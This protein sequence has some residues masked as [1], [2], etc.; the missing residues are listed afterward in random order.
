M[1]LPYPSPNSRLVV[2]SRLEGGNKTNGGQETGNTER[3]LVGGTSVARGDWAAGRGWWG[4]GAG[5]GVGWLLGV[6]S[7]AGD[8]GVARW[9]WDGSDW[10][11][12]AR[13]WVAWGSWVSWG[14]WAGAV[15]SLAGDQPIPHGTGYRNFLYHVEQEDTTDE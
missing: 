9:V 5:A 3:G 8:G 10:G 15:R 4:V 12:W 7:R 2:C 1:V 6:W 13:S 11:D 14:S